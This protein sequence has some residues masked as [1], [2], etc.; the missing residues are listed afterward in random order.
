MRY[1]AVLNVNGSDYP[2]E[3]EPHRSLLSVVRT[4]LGL[5]GSKEGCDDS[6]CGACMM[7]V[8]GSPVN[9]CSY[10]ALQA[11]GHTVVTVEGLAGED[12]LHPL[13]RQ[14]LEQGG[15]QCG[16]C[17]PGM[18]ISAKALLDRTP[19]PSEEEIR[20]ALSGN[21]CRCTGYQ[22]IVRAVQAAAA[23]MVGSEA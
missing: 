3:I 18:L 14:F 20:L 17:T 15:V 5:P 11:Q 8:D 16:F 19:N 4:E 7:L 1:D 12:G 6:E 21:L 10:L 9:S 22:G 13:Q 23:D 2:V